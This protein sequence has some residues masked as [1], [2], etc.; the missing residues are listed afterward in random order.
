MKPSDLKSLNLDE[1]WS[2]HEEIAS[3][4]ARKM[5]AEKAVLESRLQQLQLSADA[6][7]P[8]ASNGQRSHRRVFP[9]YR[10][11]AQPTETWAGRGKQPRWLSALLKS[12]KKL[13]DFR[14][15]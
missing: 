4:L 8:K 3:V 7:I 1:L 5:E 10:N 11:P 6:S 9:K 2:L 13:D 14:I 12:G 15:Q